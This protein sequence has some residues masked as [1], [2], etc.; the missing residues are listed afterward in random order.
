[1]T[2]DESFEL[3]FYICAD[4]NSPAVQEI[5]KTLR[6]AGYS[7]YL[8]IR[9]EVE[10]ELDRIAEERFKT[11]ALVLT[12]DREQTRVDLEELLSILSIRDDAPQ[13][14]IFQFERNELA[15]L[16]DAKF[17]V[18]LAGL[19]NS[20]DRRVRVLAALER[21]A[22]SVDAFEDELYSAPDLRLDNLS[23]VDSALRSEKTRASLK[24][25]VLDPLEAALSA[26]SAAQQRIPLDSLE[27]VRAQRPSAEEIVEFGVSHPTSVAIG[28]SFIVDV[29]IYCQPDRARALVRAAELRPENDRLSSAGAAPVARGTKLNISLQLP[30]DTEPKSQIVY[31][32]GAITNVS[33]RVLPTH[34]MPAPVYGT[35]KVAVGGL[36]IGQVFFRLESGSD[37]QR[38]FSRARSHKECLRLL[39]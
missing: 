20:K 1:M 23:A 22:P 10:P 26:P 25:K 31:W 5:K 21:Y 19:Y 18:D 30:W 35:C 34:L 38:S 15:A 33:F 32:S 27:T 24:K 11:I 13:V 37:D 4:R 9:T 16:I 3:D 28:I 12:S 2:G 39:Y 7:V 14:M 6:E 29:L 17:I 8:P 36:T